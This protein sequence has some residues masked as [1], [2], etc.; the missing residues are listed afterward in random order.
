MI[1]FVYALVL[2]NVGR[3]D[4]DSPGRNTD[5][6]EKSR[7]IVSIH[8]SRDSAGKQW[9]G[10]Q[11][12]VLRG[13]SRVL[14][15]FFLSLLDTTDDG[16]GSGEQNDT[17]WFE[18][19]WN[20]I[21][22][23]SFNAATETGGRDTLNLRIAGIELLVLC[24]QLACKGGAQAAVSPV[25]VGTNMEVVN[26]ALR[27]VRSP[28][29]ASPSSKKSPQKF[30]STITETWR[31][32]LFLDAFEVLDSYRE[33]LESDSL[34]DKDSTL[35]V[36]SHFAGDLNKLYE[37]CRDNEFAEERR[38]NELVSLTNDTA[39]DHQPVSEED[40]L[41]ERFV[42]IV[43]TVAMKSSGGQEARFLSQAQR[44]C[45]DL[46]RYLAQNGSSEAFINLSF[47]ASSSFFREREDNGKPKKG[48]DILSH[49]ASN[50]LCEEIPNEHV[51]DECR[52]LVLSRLLL[53]LYDRK[54]SEIEI[55]QE[56]E[57]SFKLLTRLISPCLQSAKELE[58]SIESGSDANGYEMQLLDVLWERLCVTL[59]N[60]LSL[61]SDGVKIAAIPHAADLAELVNSISESTN[62]KF[63]SKLCDILELGALRC[64]E[65]ANC[66]RFNPENLTLFGSC[67]RGICRLDSADTSLPYIANQ[68]FSAVNHVQPDAPSES[69]DFRSINFKVEACVL[70]C[71]IMQDTRGIDRVIVA[72]FPS[73]CQ[74]VR[75]E[76][77]RLREA[78]GGVLSHVNVGQLLND[79][80]T[81]CELAETRAQVAENRLSDLSSQVKQLLKEKE[82]LEQQLAFINH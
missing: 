42:R 19:A 41:M 60:M 69:E 70:A 25:R 47:L 16:S 44:S 76:D 66:S 10:T 59:T 63:S 18:Q 45:V 24:N 11:V 39:L 34:V 58:R 48:V 38:G 32:N 37:C 26:G 50:V 7:Y 22:S 80:Q 8:H 13:L 1:L 40:T 30:H 54:D 82:A 77:S 62:S 6:D 21:L 2:E 65:V 51:L 78:A 55:V 27:S 12:L 35:Q 79:T 17:P 9:M 56:D 29:K 52:V 64:L 74:L 67:F 73:L 14:R 53:V 4:N 23:H 28:G 31:E 36:L 61:A 57:V 46:L 72:V 33:Y 81:R 43:K 3:D 68:A 20:S 15:T 71:Q 5:G 75:A 49:E